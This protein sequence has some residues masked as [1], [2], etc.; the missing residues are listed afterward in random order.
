MMNIFSDRSVQQ[1]TALSPVSRPPPHISEEGPTPAR[2]RCSNV[3]AAG[4]RHWPGSRDA[5]HRRDPYS[6]TGRP[7]QSVHKH[8]ALR[9]GHWSSQKVTESVCCPSPFCTSYVESHLNE[10]LYYYYY[11]YYYIIIISYSLLTI[12]KFSES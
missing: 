5:R 2:G 6:G 9:R 12:S 8:P 7:S 11:Y 10:F 3:R 1:E 4:T